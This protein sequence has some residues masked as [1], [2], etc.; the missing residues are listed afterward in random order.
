MVQAMNGDKNAFAAIVKTYGPRMARFAYRMVGNRETALDIVQDAFVK[1]WQSRSQY[2][3]RCAVNAYLFR[4]VRNACI[5]HIRA[6]RL[7]AHV[8]L[9]DEVDIPSPSCEDAVLGRVLADAIEGAL[10]ELPELQ[11]AVFV[12]SEYERLTYEEIATIVGCPHGTVASRKFAAME[13]LRKRLRPLL[14][15]EIE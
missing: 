4:V 9:D 6:N 8:R 13:A 11:R 5:D 15:G 3:E 10:L 14:E 7:W 12:L 1:I 2:A